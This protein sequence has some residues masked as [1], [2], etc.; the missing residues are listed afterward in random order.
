MKWPLLETIPIAL[1]CAFA[2]QFLTQAFKVVFYSIKHRTWDMSYATSPGGMPST[3]AAYVSA[4][5][6]SIG[7]QHG[8]DSDLFAVSVIFGGIVVYDAA[9][10][11]R[12]VG[13]QSRLLNK[14]AK[15][16][17]PDEQV[18]LPEKMG[19]TFKEILT[20]IIFGALAGMGLTL[21]LLKL[22]IVLG[23]G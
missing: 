2:V 15:Q 4:L 17:L 22:V 8:L 9:G 3:H 5:A 19:H 21:L 20:G 12:T 13:K 23:L 18:N 16:L 10:L 7:I 6:F 14:L 1:I 11:R